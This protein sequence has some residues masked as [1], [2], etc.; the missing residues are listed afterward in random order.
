MEEVLSSIGLKLTASLVDSDLAEA[1][2]IL[3]F[4]YIIVD[5][6]MENRWTKITFF[7]QNN[8]L[9]REINIHKTIITSV[10]HGNRNTRNPIALNF[11]T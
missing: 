11:R 5:K 6:R 10:V 3:G 9:R 4:S 8:I 7:E 2:P 1:Y